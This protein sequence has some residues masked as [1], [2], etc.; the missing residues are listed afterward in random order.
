[1][2]PQLQDTLVAVA[3]APAQKELGAGV[4]LK[5]NTV[6]VEGAWAF[7]FADLQNADGGPVDYA[8]T[9]YAEGL[10]DGFVSRGYAALLKDQGGWQV[11]THIIGPTDPAWLA[12]PSEHGAPES[13]FKLPGQ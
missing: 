5:V 9:P 8:R 7:V 2:T 13:V 3:A 4:K 11:V 1:M 12:W 10:R 6:N